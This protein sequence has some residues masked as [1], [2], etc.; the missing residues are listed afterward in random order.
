MTTIVIQ[1][2]GHHVLPAVPASAVQVVALLIVACIVF[3][4]GI[5][6]AARLGGSVPQPTQ[7][8]QP[9]IPSPALH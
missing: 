4:A 2:R 1:A 8:Q 7:P 5:A 9:S 6:A 3:G